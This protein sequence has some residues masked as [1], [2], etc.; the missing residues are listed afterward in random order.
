MERQRCITWPHRGSCVRCHCRGGRR[1]SQQTR[2]AL[3]ERFH[4]YLD[5]V[6]ALADPRLV[7][8]ELARGIDELLVEADDLARVRDDNRAARVAVKGR[9]VVEEVVRVKAHKARVVLRDADGR[10]VGRLGGHVDVARDEEDY[11]APTGSAAR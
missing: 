3:D 8:E 10:R 4:G 11:G 9:R 5:V 7:L 1:R 6:E 2:Q